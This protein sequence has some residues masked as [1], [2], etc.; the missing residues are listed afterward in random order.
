MQNKGD[1]N[2]TV[3]CQA[4]QSV[5]RRPM[6]PWYQVAG[7]LGSEHS[8]E[9]TRLQ[10]AICKLPPTQEAE[11][12]EVEETKEDDDEDTCNHHENDLVLL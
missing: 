8:S 11:P 1:E 3:V 7:T 6:Q 12:V 4:R 5:L 2:E 9:A 10:D